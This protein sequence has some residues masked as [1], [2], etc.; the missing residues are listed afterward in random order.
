[1]SI[2]INKR[3]FVLAIFLFSVF[4]HAWCLRAATTNFLERKHR[5]SS[6]ALTDGEETMLPYFTGETSTCLYTVY[7]LGDSP[8][9][10]S[11]WDVYNKA[12]FWKGKDNERPHL[13]TKEIERHIKTAIKQYNIY[14]IAL[15]KSMIKSNSKGD[16]TPNADAQ[17]TTFQLKEGKW[18]SVDCFN[19]MQSPTNTAKYLLTLLNKTNPTNAQLLGDS[20]VSTHNFVQRVNTTCAENAS[21]CILEKLKINY[22]QLYSNTPSMFFCLDESHK[23]KFKS[24]KTINSIE[25]HIKTYAL[26]L[27]NNVLSDSILCYE[28]YNNAGT[29]SC[30]EKLYYVDIRK[31]KIW[32]V[33]LTYDVESVE[34]ADAEIYIIDLNRGCFRRENN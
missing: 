2:T 12:G 18:T 5:T 22:Y 4:V 20:L 25:E 1:M 27:T 32:T 8:K 3:H 23:I 9:E 33:C 10:R 11:F 17:Y 6:F 7:F 16:F 14:A 28:Y 29:L 13:Y 21:G 19:V 34:A 24:Y 30:Y 15:N 26:L 31:G